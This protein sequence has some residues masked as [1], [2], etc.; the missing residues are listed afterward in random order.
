MNI[1]QNI[2]NLPRNEKLLIMEYIWKDLSEDNDKFESPEWHKSVL[3][4]TE[5]RI[6]EG[7]EKKIDWTEAKIQLRET[8]R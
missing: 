7:Q 4:E 3:Y 5:K 2:V 1:L 8:F 6:E